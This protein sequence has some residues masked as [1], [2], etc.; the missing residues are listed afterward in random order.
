[1]HTISIGEDGITIS[2]GANTPINIRAGS[3]LTLEA[4]RNIHINGR[5]IDFNGQRIVNP[6]GREI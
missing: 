6:T 1:M 5:T 4:S 3:D 2:S